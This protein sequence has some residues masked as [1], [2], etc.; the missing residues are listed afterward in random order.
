[1]VIAMILG[2][3]LV[4]ATATTTVYTQ[5]AH[6]L[7]GQPLPCAAGPCIPPAGSSSGANGVNPGGSTINPGLTMACGIAGPAA[8][9]PNCQ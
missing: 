1:M 8:N 9:N 2:I 7:R 3:A 4:L 5:S 6:G